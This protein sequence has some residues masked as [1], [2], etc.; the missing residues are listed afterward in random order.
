MAVNNS[1]NLFHQFFAARPSR[2][3][4]F[5]AGRKLWMTQI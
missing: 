4:P 1:W 3:S 2:T 5:G